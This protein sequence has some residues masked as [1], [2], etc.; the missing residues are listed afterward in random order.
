[1]HRHWKAE[2]LSNLM[3]LILVLVLMVNSGILIGF[4]LMTAYTFDSFQDILVPYADYNCIDSTVT[5][6]LSA[7]LL[8]APGKE[9]RL[10]LAEKHFLVNRCR[11]LMDE[12]IGR[13]FSAKVNTD[14]G[15]VS[16]KI[17]G[18]TKI[19]SLSFRS[20]SVPIRISSFHGR[21]PLRFLLWNL[22]LLGL[23]LLGWF[24]F[25]KIRGN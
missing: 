21:I 9:N 13:N 20:S 17:Q 19:E 18:E 22:L 1:M 25:H 4:Q 2:G 16:V 23:E 14:L 6:D 12:E 5:N 7:F 10:I 24:L 15:T 11:V 8:A 3:I